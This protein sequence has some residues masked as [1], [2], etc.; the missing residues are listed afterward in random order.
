[1]KQ[2]SNCKELLWTGE[3]LVTSI[4]NYGAID[5]LHRYAI[6][7][8]LV[9]EKNVLDVASGEGYGS[10]LLA[11]RAR[12]VTGVDLSQEAINHAKKKYSSV[13]LEFRYGSATEMPIATHSIDMVVS[14]ETIE[15]HDRH[16]E[17]LSEIK[18]V[19]KPS[20]LLIMSSPDKLNYSESPGIVNPFHVKEL[21]A[22]E[23]RRLIQSY[24]GKALF[25]SQKHVFGSIITVDDA[26]GPFREFS[27]D[28]DNVHETPN[29]SSPVYNICLASNGAL[30]H[31]PH[32]FFCGKKATD[33]PD[34]ARMAAIETELLS[35]KNS[36]SFQL[37]TLAS[38]FVRG[39]RRLMG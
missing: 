17:M 20:G 25:L 9:D 8:S 12:F 39:V 2:A 23:F 10:A 38:Q 32:S 24:F 15:H 13:N 29:I 4:F 28:Y 33:C 31:L 34:V 5:H 21:Y 18:R 7:L 1:M 16:E 19:L 36:R 30:P 35:L 14:F 6:A 22:D 37:A 11:Q 26:T 3:R 27:G